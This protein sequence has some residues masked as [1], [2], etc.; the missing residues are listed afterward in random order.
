MSYPGVRF[1][2]ALP[3]TP[4]SD[5]LAAVSLAPAVVVAD[6]R[7]AT[8][9]AVAIALSVVAAAA[10]IVIATPRIPAVW[11]FVWAAG[12]TL[13]GGV[14]QRHERLV[15]RPFPTLAPPGYRLQRVEEDVD[16]DRYRHGVTVWFE[17]PDDENSISYSSH[18]MIAPEVLDYWTRGDD[19]F[20]LEPV[21]VER[22][23]EHAFCHQGDDVFR[24]THVARCI[25][26]FDGMAI[27][28]DSANAK[29][30]RGNLRHAVTLLRAGVEHWESLRD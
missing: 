17:G 11:S 20:G 1:L 12:D 16:P 19:V 8:L 10:V 3:L 7:R 5:R 28:A 29:P 22:L 9:R 30:A 13:N 6:Q 26:A 21:A 23:G 15:D 14:E 18:G 2:G 4:H 27:I 24:E 25:A